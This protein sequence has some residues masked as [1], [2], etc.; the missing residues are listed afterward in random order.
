MDTT[1]S[2]TPPPPPTPA[3]HTAPCVTSHHP[4]PTHT[5]TDK[6]TH[7]QTQMAAVRCVFGSDHN[8]ISEKI[9]SRRMS[10]GSPDRRPRCS[11]RSTEAWKLFLATHRGDG[12]EFKD[13]QDNPG[14]AWCKGGEGT[15]ADVGQSGEKIKKKKSC[16]Q[17]LQDS[18]RALKCESR[19]EESASVIWVFLFF[20]SERRAACIFMQGNQQRT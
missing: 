20:Q 3:C 2:L 17:R 14:P 9:T 7:T 13:R 6:Q 1:V 16:V 5:H 12:L 19:R 8:H 18:Q 15:V 10:S 11:L 4:I